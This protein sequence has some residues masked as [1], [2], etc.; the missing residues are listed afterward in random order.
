M[1]INPVNMPTL[2]GTD[3]GFPVK[4]V[5]STI[6]S[7]Q[8]L[9]AVAQKIMAAARTTGLFTFVTT[10]LKIDLNKLHINIDRN[11]VSDLGLTASQVANAL[12]VMVGDANVTRFNLNSHSYEVIPQVS[13]KDRL[14]PDELNHIYVRAPSGDMIP[15]SAFVTFTSIVE[16]N[17][18]NQ[19][20][21]LNSA[22]IQG[23]LMPNAAIGD[24]LSFLQEK[25]DELMPDG[26]SYDYAGQSRQY[27]D[28]GNEMIIAM[29]FALIII[30]LVLA[31]QFDSFREPFV[32]LSS[33]FFSAFGALLA[34]T[35]TFTGTINIFTQIGLLTLI[36]LISKHGI[37]I[38]EFANQIQED[39]GLSV[40]DA[41]VKAAVM[42]LRP[43]LMTTGAM[44]CAMVPLLFSEMGL[45]NSQFQ[46]ALTIVFGMLIGT[47]FTI[48]VIP[49]LYYLV[50]EDKSKK[51]VHDDV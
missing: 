24:A 9:D 12:A 40:F 51:I 6:D 42:R 47:L 25:A 34:L 46:L 45:V 2:P 11:M 14:N 36:G 39:E 30:F 10:D 27:I 7:Y 20:Q 5:L 1:N 19:F 29:C 15:L 31:A 35:F 37:L 3:V 8:S 33:F 32:I 21:Q 13:R 44:V 4:F 23:M 38:V 22:T 26:M 41:V 48:F 17:S 49:T 16:P 28:Q 43:I 18:Y 50:A